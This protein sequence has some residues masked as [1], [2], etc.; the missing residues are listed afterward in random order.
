MRSFEADPDPIASM[1]HMTRPA[2]VT[3]AGPAQMVQRRKGV[4]KG[5]IERPLRSSCEID[6]EISR[7]SARIA[8]LQLEHLLFDFPSLAQYGFECLTPILRRYK[9]AG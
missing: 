3:F 7:N 8:R 9:R 2:E 4:W 1:N 6:G 5:L